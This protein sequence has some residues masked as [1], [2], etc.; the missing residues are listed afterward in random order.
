MPRIDPDDIIPDSL[1]MIVEEVP[2][3]QQ[4]TELSP[5]QIGRCGDVEAVSNGLRSAAR[6]R[7]Q[8]S[9]LSVEDD[10]EHA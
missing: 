3:S 10:H 4:L 5:R 7:G 9:K 1:Q 2:K 8:S 6:A